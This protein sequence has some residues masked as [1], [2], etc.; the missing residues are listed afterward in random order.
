M[1]DTF[2]LMKTRAEWSEAVANGDTNLT[3]SEWYKQK[4]LKSQVTG[5]PEERET[6][7]SLAI[8]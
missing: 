6:L 1:A 2:G 8:K 4:K 3:H 7:A 5:K